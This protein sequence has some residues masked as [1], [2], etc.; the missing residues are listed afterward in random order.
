MSKYPVAL[1]T[2]DLHFSEKAPVCRKEDDW[3][4]YQASMMRWLGE[5]KKKLKCDLF[6]VGDLFD[7]AKVSNELLNLTIDNMPSCYLTI[8]NHDILYHSENLL[9][10]SGI[11]SLARYDKFILLNDSVELENKFEF[12]P[13]HF[14]HEL[15]PYEGDKIGVAMIHELAWEKPPF[16]GADKK[17]N[18]KNLVKQ[19]YGF[20]FVFCG[21]NHEKFITHVG[22]VTVVNHGSL[23]RLKASQIDYQ[24]SVWVLY[25]DGSVE[26]IDVPIEND[27]ISREH[28]E[29]KEIKDERIHEFV[30]SLKESKLSVDLNF[31]E[32]LKINLATNK[33]DDGVIEL[34]EEASDTPLK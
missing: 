27:K 12:V 2:S 21:D 13:F 18:I 6:V 11:G 23:M 7:K 30:S 3:F 22:D 8:G 10:K 33:I 28:L 17:G 25:D 4:E 16:P 15:K 26:S 5:T 19:L 14:G 1:F 31:I 32:N 34:L 9:D 20:D 24:P 29:L